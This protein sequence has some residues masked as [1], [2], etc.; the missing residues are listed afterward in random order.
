MDAIGKSIKRHA[1]KSATKKKPKL[2]KS[3]PHGYG[4]GWPEAKDQPIFRS[5]RS[6]KEDGPKWLL[7]G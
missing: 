2:T 1:K 7:P 6:E 5:L 4:M 3:V